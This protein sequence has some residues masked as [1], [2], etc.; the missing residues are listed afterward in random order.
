[1]AKLIIFAFLLFQAEDP[2][3]LTAAIL[4]HEA[5][6][7]VCALFFTRELP[8]FSI[9]TAGFKISYIGI[10]GCSQQVIVALA[11]PFVNILS[12]LILY[13]EGIFPLY[14][15]GLGVV[16]LL[17]ISILDG[18]GILRAICEKVFFPATA[19]TVCR[20]T[21]V[22]TLL[23]LFTLNCA[24]QLKIGTNLSLAV[25]SVFLTVSVLGRDI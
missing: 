5:A 7:L 24:I 22:V 11:G 19:Y 12:G 20:F 13:K 1:M 18:G 4:C 16:N 9:S 17:P 25:I 10:T 14:S 6:H 15:L 23:A 3:T 2:L 8:I 21:S